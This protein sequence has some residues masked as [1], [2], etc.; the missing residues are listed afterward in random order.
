MHLAP[1]VALLCA[2]IT[3]NPLPVAAVGDDCEACAPAKICRDHKAAD[4]A[5]LERLRDELE[6]EDPDLREG[7]LEKAAELTDSHANAPSKAVAQ[8]LADALEDDLLRVRVVAIRLLCDGQHPEVSVKATVEVLGYLKKNMWTLVE[9]LMGPKHERGDVS[10]AMAFLRATV[11]G[12]GN[13]RDDRIVRALIQILK[14]YPTEMRGEPVA[15]ATSQSLLD[16]GTREAVAAVIEQFASRP[17]ESR[18][19]KIHSALEAYAADHDIF[20]TPEFNEDDLGRAWEAWFKK[21]KRTLPK[22]LGKWELPR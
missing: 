7:A 9:T 22:K 20:E 16:L 3:S 11:V 15:M 12:A 8:V 5:E 19:R 17:E 21:N 13:L 1:V 18:R 14:A 10:Q 4:Q 2:S 6:S